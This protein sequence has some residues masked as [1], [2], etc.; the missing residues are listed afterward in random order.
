MGVRDMTFDWQDLSGKAVN[1]G[2]DGIYPI[3]ESGSTAEDEL[4]EA[5]RRGF[6]EGEAKGLERALRELDPSRQAAENAANQL[7]TLREDLTSRTQENILALALAVARRVMEQ[8]IQAKPEY[9][10]ELVEKAIGHFPLDQKVRVR[11][12]PKD[13]AFLTGDALDQMPGEKVSREIRWTPDET[14]SPGGCIVEGPE[15]VVDGRL[16]SALERIYRTVF[17]D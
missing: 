10:A 12:N 3:Q 5:F 2:P 16:D 6:Q 17:N 4:D 14:V 15:H 11:I 8:E 9:V 13:L 7:S 1:P